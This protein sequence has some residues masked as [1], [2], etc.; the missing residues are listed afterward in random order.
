[1]NANNPDRPGLP[2]VGLLLLAMLAAT[3]L[4]HEVAAWIPQM[5]FPL[6]VQLTILALPQLLLARLLGFQSTTTFAFRS[7]G[8]GRSIAVLLIAVSG[9][10]VLLGVVNLQDVV[11]GELGVSTREESAELE[12]HIVQIEAT[13]ILFLVLGVVVLPALCEELFFRGFL[14]SGFVNAFGPTR[15]VIY[16]ALLFGAMHSSMIK[17]LPTTLLG[18]LFGF[19][20]VRTR[21]IVASIV[22][23]LMNNLCVILF[24]RIESST[25]QHIPTLIIFP[26][27]IALALALGYVIARSP[28]AN[29]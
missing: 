2:A 11:F 25:F 21:S 4:V 8:V 3:L 18:L 19:L 26:A 14:Q 28:S 10:V 1:M 23:H 29:D 24:A 15:G 9:F 27:L 22:A 5:V 7:L 16:T 6:V 17:L 20:V 13:G 12:R